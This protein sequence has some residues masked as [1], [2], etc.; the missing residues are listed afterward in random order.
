MPF[1]LVWRDHDGEYVER[2]D[3]EDA[4]YERYN[5]LMKKRNGP[6]GY[7][8]HVILIVEG[9]FEITEM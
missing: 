2:P 8:T 7:G 1:F 6:D 4:L 5:A 3:D 9:G